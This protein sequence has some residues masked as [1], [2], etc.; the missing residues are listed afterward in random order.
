MQAYL[1]ENEEFL[2]F[3]ESIIN[4]IHG[5]EGL[6]HV[7]DLDNT[8]SR[9]RHALKWTLKSLTD[10]CE[11]LPFVES[12]PD[13]IRGL[14][15]LYRA[16]AHLFLPLLNSSDPATSVGRRILDLLRGSRDPSLDA[17]TQRRR[18]EACIK[19]I[20]ALVLIQNPESPSQDRGA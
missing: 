15:G 16:N 3:V 17:L 8:E 12:I 9:D 6:P 4:I 10:D 13:A 2:P 5:P 14:D 11:L 7:N 19:A 1:I 18:Q 20:W